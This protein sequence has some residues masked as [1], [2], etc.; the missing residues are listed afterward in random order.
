M[1]SAPHLNSRDGA[2]GVQLEGFGPT[3]NRKVVGSNPTSGS[4][5]AGQRAFLALLTAQRQRAVIPLGWIIAPQAHCPAS[6]R[7]CAARLPAGSGSDVVRRNADC[8]VGARPSRE[9]DRGAARF[10]RLRRHSHIPPGGFPHSPNL[11][12]MPRSSS[13]DAKAVTL[14]TTLRALAWPPDFGYHH[15]ATVLACKQE[16]QFE[17]S[18]RTLVDV[19]G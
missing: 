19:R 11:D 16:R 14:L 13:T 15:L 4:K 3:R 9:V 6:L 10:M 18:L 7:R 1:K 17:S 8:N 12:R 5:T 2:R